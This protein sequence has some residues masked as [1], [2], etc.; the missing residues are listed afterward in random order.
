MKSFRFTLLEFSFTRSR[1]LVVN[2]LI[3]VFSLVSSILVSFE[4][5]AYISQWTK[6]T[7]R[8][9]RV[10]TGKPTMPPRIYVIPATA[11]AFMTPYDTP[12]RMKSGGLIRAIS[13]EPQD[14]YSKTKQTIVDV[15]SPGHLSIAL[16]GVP[17][18]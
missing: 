3:S 10:E 7:V 14:D 18:P 15:N 9:G 11:V 17:I 2:S 6:P 5:K 1:I 16:P 8:P 4:A 13:F 12:V